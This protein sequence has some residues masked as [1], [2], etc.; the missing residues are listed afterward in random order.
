MG[1]FT[2]KVERKVYVDEQGRSYPYYDFIVD[3][4]GQTFHLK[5]DVRVKS[6]VKYILDQNL[7]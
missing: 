2:L 4:Y 1:E 7:D 3:L 5:P 6:L